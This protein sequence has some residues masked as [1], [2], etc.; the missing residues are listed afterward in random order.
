M[1]SEAM[2]VSK[3]ILRMKTLK[4]FLLLGHPVHAQ[5]IALQINSINFIERLREYRTC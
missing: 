4:L 1:A 3:E 5:L 2:L